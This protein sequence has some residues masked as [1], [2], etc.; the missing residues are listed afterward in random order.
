MRIKTYTPRAAEIEREWFV[1]DAKD[2]TLGRLATQIAVLLRGKHKPMFSPHMDV[3]DYVI[4][5]NC[6][7]IR[8]TGRKLDQKFYYRH[9]G[10]PGGLKSESLREMLRRHPERVIQTAVR[11]MLPKNRLGRKMIKKLKIYAGDT[12]PHQAQKPK[13]FEL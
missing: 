6:D 1:I 7:K 9:S 3:G 5:L 13:V 11:G 2:Q 12:H 4:V 10:Y 8:V